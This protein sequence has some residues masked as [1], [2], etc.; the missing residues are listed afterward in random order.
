MVWELSR[1]GNLGFPTTPTISVISQNAHRTH[2]SAIFK[3]YHLNIKNA[4]EQQM[5]RYSG[6][7]WKSRKHKSFCLHGV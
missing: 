3:D 7:V 5:K 4:N 2:K 1:D 6:Q